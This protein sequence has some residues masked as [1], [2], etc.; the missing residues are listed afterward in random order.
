MHSVIYVQFEHWACVIQVILSRRSGTSHGYNKAQYWDEYP[1]SNIVSS[2]VKI[3]AL[4][5]YSGSNCGLIE[6]EFYTGQSKY[7]LSHHIW[8]CLSGLNQLSI[9]VSKKYLFVLVKFTSVSGIR[10]IPGETIQLRTH[11]IYEECAICQLSIFHDVTCI[12][13]QHC[14][15]YGRGVE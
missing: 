7:T 5:V 4:S 2:Q 6:V 1:L 8:I 13:I 10:V 9:A 12:I 3:E 15:R 11:E 14:L